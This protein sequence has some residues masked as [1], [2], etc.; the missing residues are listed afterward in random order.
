MNWSKFIKSSLLHQKWVFLVGFSVVFMFWVLLQHALEK[1]VQ[2]SLD[3]QVTRNAVLLHALEDSVVRSFQSVNASVKTLAESLPELGRQDEIK[4]VIQEQLHISPQIRSIDLLDVKG[5][6]KVSAVGS[7]GEMLNYSCI[8]ALLEDPLRE[9]QI[10]TPVSGRYPGD[11]FS[12]RTPQQH[13]PFCISVKDELGQIRSIL[14]ASINPQYFTRLFQGV[15]EGQNADIS[16]YRYDGKP[17]ITSHN[18][19]TSN[20]FLSKLDEKSWGEYR[21]NEGS[22][23]ATLLSYRSTT[24]L[25][26]IVT[27]DSSEREALK[28]WKRDE[29][30]L[31]LVMMVLSGLILLVCLFVVLILERRDRVVG[32]NHL[33][34]TAIRST[35]NAVFITD[36]KGNISWVNDAFTKLTGYNFHEVE[37]ENPR[38]LNSGQHSPAYF[39]HFW[40]CIISGDS[41]RGELVNR[42]KDGRN[43]IVEQT[44]TPIVDRSGGIN[45]FVAVHE[46]VTARRNAE[47]KALY[48]AD[49]DSL[50][51]LPNRRYFE[52]KLH[53]TFSQETEGIAAILFI[54]LDRFKEINDTMGH[55]AGDA[56]LTNTTDNLSNTLNEE[57]LLARLGGDE[58]S[59]LVY[60][61]QHTDQL[62]ILAQ[63]LIKAVACPFH[64]GDNTFTVTCSVGI[65]YSPIPDSDA[66]LLL[67]QAD[68]A[69]YRAKHEGKNTYRFFD[70]AMDELMKRRVFLQQQ[71]EHAVKSDNELSLKYQPQISTSSG[72]VCG[73]EALMR[74]ETDSG[75]W[76][77]PVEFISLAEETGLILEVG[78]WLMES[79][80]S[81]MACWNKDGLPFGRIAM[82]ISAVQLARENLAERLLTLMYRFEI[83]ASQVSIEITETTLMVDSELVSHNLSLLKKAGLTLAIDDFGT[84]YSSLS[85]LKALDAD[86][87]KIDRSF[88]IGIGENRSDESI[89]EATIAL[90]H[91]LNL[92]TVAEGVDNDVQLEFLDQA[93]CDVIQGYL[94]AKPLSSNEFEQFVLDQSKPRG[95]GSPNVREDIHEYI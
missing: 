89:I 44:V 54:D 34:S 66:S 90:A 73:A 84:G 75:E 39:K 21:V 29:R 79:M 91:R 52:Q 37:G 25:P 94:F 82:N 85:Y 1:G 5:L 74:W 10:D 76:I 15:L 23:N 64:Y 87:L 26:L 8:G 2:R 63:Q 80:F 38:I 53:D 3:E 65:A 16:L 77:S 67:R 50:T 31:S 13:I 69:M 92:K 86:Y 70:T 22:S 27:I 78:N 51:G 12:G 72:R 68:M 24:L 19:P 93:G 40:L 62:S 71:L 6:V 47:Q 46:D 48:L 88:V 81:Q 43:M 32:D 9:Y 45:H 56:L 58:F 59:V 28:A 11:P 4:K 60:P 42:H 30:M 55:E 20:I 36:K 41:W 61:I 95:L 57:Y 35:A 14:L 83:P 33:L 7:E 17:L 18:R 49:H